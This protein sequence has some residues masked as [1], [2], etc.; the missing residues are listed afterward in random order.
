MKIGSSASKTHKLC[1][2]GSPDCTRRFHFF[3]TT[4]MK[5]RSRLYLSLQEYKVQNTK[6][7]TIPEITK[8]IA[9][10]QQTR[11]KVSETWIIYG[12]SAWHANKHGYI[13]STKGTSS[14]NTLTMILLLLLLLRKHEKE[15]KKQVCFCT[16]SSLCKWVICFSC[17]LVGHNYQS[18][19]HNIDITP[20]MRYLWCRTW[21]CLCWKPRAIRSPLLL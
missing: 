1:V 2:I 12:N 13:N 17:P 5:I 11:D 21:G 6:A 19:T 14:R 4:S 20:P 16:Y 18:E 10:A 8:G 15:N 9:S 3:Y 7:T